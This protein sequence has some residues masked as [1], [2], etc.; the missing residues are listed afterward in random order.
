MCVFRQ[1]CWAMSLSLTHSGMN[2]EEKCSRGVQHCS[3]SGIPPVLRMH[4]FHPRDPNEELSI[5]SSCKGHSSQSHDSDIQRRRSAK[6]LNGF[7]EAAI[8][9]T[10]EQKLNECEQRAKAF[11]NQ[12]NSSAAIQ[13]LVRCVALAR[14]TYGDEH[15]KLAQSHANL[16][17]GYLQFKGLPLQ[18]KL[19]TKK[20]HSVL[21]NYLKQIG[22][23]EESEVMKSLICI[24]LTEAG[25]SIRLIKFHE[26]FSLTRTT[27]KDAELCLGKAEKLVAKFR[28]LEVFTKEELTHKEKE[29][30]IN[31]ARLYQKQGKQ[32]ESL[33]Y[34]EKALELTGDC[35]VEC[36]QRIALY[37]E[38]A[39]LEQENGNLHRA[40]EHLQQAYDI[41]LSQSATGTEAADIAHCL[42]KVCSASTEPA[43]KGHASQFFEESLKSYKCILGAENSKYLVVQDDFCH[44]LISAGEA[45]N[46]AKI[47]KRSLETK[48]ATFGELSTEVAETY[49]LLGAVECSLGLQKKA[50]I[51]LNKCLQIQMLHFGPSHKKTKETQ[52]TIDFLSKCPEVGIGQQRS[53]NSRTRP[54]FSA[55]FPSCT[56]RGVSSSISN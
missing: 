40:V 10:P 6:T 1:F 36:H 54:Q 2:E 28:D 47:L 20:A 29:L 13:E 5:H 42:A 24:F 35:E 43:H 45:E 14:I 11:A 19:H 22:Q 52:K 21:L 32:S 37:K 30:V 17:Q 31:F 12:G 51:S 26:I 38:M 27:L 8:M 44:F 39:V 3:L 33:S 9:R 15:W 4:E 53:E 25:A 7:M 55:V 18:A 16:A 34:Y 41:A 48:K 56:V 23:Q 49:Q 46:A 50:Y